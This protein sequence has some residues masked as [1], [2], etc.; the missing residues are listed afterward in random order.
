MSA[1]GC[2]N[3][4]DSVTTTQVKLGLTKEE[5]TELAELTTKFE[6]FTINKIKS[7]QRKELQV[8]INTYII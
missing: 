5:E 8:Y 1:A 6:N 2:E 7:R 4:N 3:T